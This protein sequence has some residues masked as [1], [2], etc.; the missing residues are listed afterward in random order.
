MPETRLAKARA[1]LPVGYQFGMCETPFE[2]LLRLRREFIDR[3]S[4]AI[5]RIVPNG[6][7]FLAYNDDGQ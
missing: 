5:A 6:I 4:H 1:T 3:Q 2:R 7:E